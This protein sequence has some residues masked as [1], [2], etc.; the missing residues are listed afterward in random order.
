MGKKDE[1]KPG[2]VESWEAFRFGVVGPLLASPPAKGELQAEIAKLAAKG[3]LPPGYQIPVK[4]GF[5]TIERWYYAAREDDKDP[6]K[7]LRRKVR[8]D[9]GVFKSLGEPLRAQLHAQWKQHKSWSYQ[10]HYDNLK[11][12]AA[13]DPKLGKV[14]G[15]STVRRYMKATG[16]LRQPR[17]GDLTRP[18]VQRAE[19][20]LEQREVRSWEVEQPNALWHLDFHS[21]SRQVLTAKG[22]RVT[23][24]LLG[25]IDDHSRL[26]CHLQWYLA[27]TAENLIHGLC[28][29]FAKR[30]L[31]RALMT[32]N[33]SAMVAGET[34]TGL[35]ECSVVHETTLPHSPY[36]N[37]KQESFWGQVEGRLMAMLERVEG[38]TLEQLNEA[39]Q[40][41][42]EME[43]NR[44]RHDELGETPLA[45]WLSGKDAGRPCPSSEQLRLRFTERVSRRQ[46][47]SDGTI[48]LQSIRFELPARYR[49]LE[50]VTIR[51]ASWDLSHVWLWDARNGLALARLFPLDKRRNADGRRRALVDPVT[52]SE[53]EPKTDDGLPPLLAALVESYRATGLPP[54]YLPKHESEEEKEEESR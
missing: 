10:L 13:A 34:T 35:L 27:E 52:A 48:S 44:K 22:E 26:C 14:P 42:V 46:R 15:Y 28:Q 25:I 41:W 3:W 49:H 21:C 19:Q 8:K 30:G 53:L 12:A 23:P 24:H 40:A 18:G 54:A 50:E 33:G 20:R 7:A 29:A 38:L 47:R 45:R 9:L 31:P 16:M 4:Y 17:R 36:Q 11:A 1:K 2:R 5:S 6:V 37:G 43:Y 39:T 32:D 51:Y